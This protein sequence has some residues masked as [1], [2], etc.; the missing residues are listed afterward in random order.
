MK[1]RNANLDMIRV[2]SMTCV[3][4]M[5]TPHNPWMDIPVIGWIVNAFIVASNSHFFMLSGQMNLAKTFSSREDYR[6]YYI[7]RLVSIIFPYLLVT[8]A[9]TLWNM[10]LDGQTLAFKSYLKQT[11]TDLMI[12]NGEIHFW[13]MY[14]LIGMMISAPFLSRMFHAMEDWELSLIMAIGLLWG[15]VS[16]YMTVDIGVGFSYTG[17]FMAGWPL[18]FFAGY[19]C[20]RVIGKGKRTWL[21]AAGL[22]G[23]VVTTVGCAFFSDHFLFAMDLS[24]VYLLFVMAWYV[25]LKDAFVVSNRKVK[26][27]L[28]F[29]TRHTFT[30]Y[31]IHYALIHNVTLKLFDS[32]KLPYNYF[33]SFAFSYG[34]SLLTAV[35]LDTVLIIP[36]QRQLRRL[37]LGNRSGTRRADQVKKN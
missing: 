21:Y 6:V 15:V 34:L 24:P 2:W 11:Y 12:N 13:F 17:W 32:L 1:E 18:T 20:D 14:P 25:F 9:L 22:F 27:F 31:L 16:I 3:L 26:S 4:L 5:H 19:Y 10:V 29:M 23:L 37:L 7:K 33:L 35:V 36:V 28:T 30:I 8:M